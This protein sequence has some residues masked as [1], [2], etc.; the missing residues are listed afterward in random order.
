MTDRDR[1]Q[2][3]LEA[4]HSVELHSSELRKELRLGDLVF[5]QMAY[6]IGM[7]WIGTAGKLGSAHIM[8]WIPAVLLFYIPSGMVVVHLNQE[9]PLE[10]GLYQWAKL[11]FGDL[12]GFLTA[13]NIWATLVLILA[14][15]V[16]QI[17][18]NLAY[19]AGPSGAWMVE[20]KLITSA[21]GAALMGGLMLV[22]MRGLAMAKWFHNAGGFVVLVGLAG[23]LLFALPRWLHGGAAVAPAALT[24][25]AVSLL[26]LNILGKMGFGAFCG[27]D[28]CAIF[29]GEVR[30]PRVART[31]R[32]SV[33]LSAPLIALFYI[34]GT[35]C[36]LAFSRPA[37]IDLLAPT[38]Q[39]LS[40]G[41]QATSVA[42]L[43]APFVAA[44]MICNLIGSSSIYNNALIRLPMV[45]G[46][47][48][49]LPQ[50]F[51]RLHPRFK[52]PVGSILC[53]GATAFGLTVLGNV[54]TGAQESFQL[55]NSA[56]LICWALTYLVMFAIPLAAPGEKPRWG[57]R[58]AA[59]SGFAMS[60]L[61][62]ILSIFPI[63]D[64]ANAAAFTAK[65][66]GV[67]G[68]INAVGAWYFWRAN[69][70]REALAAAA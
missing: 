41:A 63:V 3:L 37:D 13:L 67:V 64:V 66:V 19:A 53:I 60:L 43:V 46:W 70:R 23:M 42:F 17:T 15:A 14:S 40:R 9:M 6:I 35:A 31:I 36:A 59:A 28:G 24:F 27:F 29:S 4:E 16:S 8:Y 57:L 33:W 44:L 54:G 32:R 11:R 10:G 22:A 48:H 5:S 56:G 62:V 25:P 50:W 12:A 21:V 18:D 30:D 65:V 49:L 7:Q 39:A 61:Y 38:T 26:N 2:Q 45:A 51:S 20:N 34:L 68:G 58:V 52:T 55:L 47:D 69:K 1:E